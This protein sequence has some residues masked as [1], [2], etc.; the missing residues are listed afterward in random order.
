MLPLTYSIDYTKKNKE[1]LGQYVVYPHTEKSK[2][3]MYPIQNERKK[4]LWKIKS[5]DLDAIKTISRSVGLNTKLKPIISETNIHT[6][7]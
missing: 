5:I 2:H 4:F 1:Q 6:T 7:S 3:K